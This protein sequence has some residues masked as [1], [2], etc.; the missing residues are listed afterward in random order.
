MMPKKTKMGPKLVSP[1]RAAA[2]AIFARNDGA[3]DATVAAELGT[4]RQRISKLHADWKKVVGNV[5]QVKTVASESFPAQPASVGDLATGRAAQL[6]PGDAIVLMTVEWPDWAEPAEMIA[7]RHADVLD[8]DRVQSLVTFRLNAASMPGSF[9]ACGIDPE[10]GRSLYRG[11][12]ALR[13]VMDWAS[14]L[15]ELRLSSSML[16][17]A[18]G[19]GPQA[20]AAATLVAERQL[21]W[22]RES[23]LR[24]EGEIEHKLDIMALI[25]N[26]ET[27]AAVSALEAAMQND[28]A[29]LPAHEDAIDGEI[30]ERPA[31]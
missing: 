8:A 15:A 29:E 12:R 6:R 10:R 17:L 23:T 26:P 16:R 22:T 5:S 2:Y 24:I 14:G 18:G 30:V 11:D 28:T 27:I 7:A 25:A 9:K 13:R 4:S 21:G 20:V 1:T 19:V 3:S 31:A